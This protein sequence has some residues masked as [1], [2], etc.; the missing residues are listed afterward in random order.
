[1]DDQVTKEVTLSAGM[2]A[3]LEGLA[4]E[5]GGTVNQAVYMAVK[6]H[7]EAFKIDGLAQFLVDCGQRTVA[8][9]LAQA[10][11]TQK[12]ERAAAHAERRRKERETDF[13]PLPLPVCERC[14]GEAGALHVWEKPEGG[15]EHVCRGC[16]LGLGQPFEPV[17]GFPVGGAQ[18]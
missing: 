13:R 12:A 18:E 7:L 16:L 14:G 11:A 10:V 3:L 17:A 1:M 9:V 5:H 6:R 4:E 2:W 15:E 8:D